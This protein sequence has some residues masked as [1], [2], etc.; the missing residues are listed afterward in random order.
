MPDDDDEA[1]VVGVDGS[2]AALHAVR[3]AALAAAYRA[4]PLRLVHV[5]TVPVT[6]PSSVAP[7]PRVVREGLAAQGT[8]WLTTAALEATAHGAVEMELVEWAPVPALLHESARARMVVLGT[9]GLGG[10]TTMLVGSTAT[11]LVT[12]G[13]CPVVVVRGRK[14]GDVPPQTGPVVVGVDGSAEGEAALGFACEEA[15]LRG[16]SI[17]AVHTWSQLVSGAFQAHASAADPA[18][19]LEEERRKLV[20]Q[21][22][23]WQDKYPRLTIEA[24]VERGHPVR[25]LVAH[26]EHARLIV[27]GS[28]GRGGFPGMLLGSTSRSLIA[29][30]PCP[31]AVVRPLATPAGAS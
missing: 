26:G 24:V 10:F 8:T 20:E 7:P 29:H 1:V 15:S 17:T 11:A 13:H 31:V 25:T 22:A 12:H 19:I 4:L 30:S 23:S 21:L 18:R 3:W 28:R 6:G 2:E 27:A 5:Y 16:G 14:P 9:R